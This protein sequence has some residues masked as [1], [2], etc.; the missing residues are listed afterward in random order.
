LWP[1]PWRR[2]QRSNQ[3]S[4]ILLYILLRTIQLLF[5]TFFR[6]FHIYRDICLVRL[7]WLT[8]CII[9][10]NVN[11]IKITFYWLEKSITAK[12]ARL[13]KYRIS[14]ILVLNI[15]IAKKKITKKLQMKKKRVQFIV[16]QKFKNILRNFYEWKFLWIIFKWKVVW[17]WQFYPI[18]PN[19]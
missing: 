12:L 19:F 6:I 18:L 17:F 7:K 16:L 3:S 15:I 13:G 9:S 11:N 14:T 1:W 10:N 8:L 4:Y 2:H 5:E